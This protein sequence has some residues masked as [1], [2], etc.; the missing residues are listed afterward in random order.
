ME[1]LMIS[2]NGSEKI[3]T[4]TIKEFEAHKNCAE[5]K[6]EDEDDTVAVVGE[7]VQVAFYAYIHR[8][9]VVIT[10]KFCPPMYTH[11]IKIGSHDE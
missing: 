6:I 1:R 9:P 8:L 3:H 4:G 10:R 2:K 5:I 11:S 7:Q